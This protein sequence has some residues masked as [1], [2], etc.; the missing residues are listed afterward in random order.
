MKFSVIIPLFN[1]A[2]YVAETLQSIFAQTFTDW[3]LIVIDDGSTDDSLQVATSVIEDAKKS[4]PIGKLKLISQSNA[5]V[6][7][8]RNNGVAASQGEYICFLDADDWWETTF[9]EEIDR[10]IN[11]F[12]EAGIYGAS[13]NIVKNGKN[14]VAPIAFDVGFERGYFNYFEVYSRYL[15]MPL[16]TGAVCVKKVVFQELNGFNPQLKIGED[17]DLWIRIALRYKTASVNKPLSYY[18]QDVIIEK[19]ALNGS[20]HA[21]EVDFVFNTDKLIEAEQENRALKSLLDK[22]RVAFIRQYYFNKSRRQDAEHELAKVDWGKFTLA[23]KMWYLAP[24]PVAKCI[25]CIKRKLYYYYKSIK[26]K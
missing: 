15:C 13:Y 2:Q 23:K 20:L 3:E 4:F 25:F 14:L 26:N 11:D 19:R 7:T 8:A 9:L 21:K 6:S 24:Y 1:K 18:N 17:F 10:L 22:Q 5:G 16:W 12:P